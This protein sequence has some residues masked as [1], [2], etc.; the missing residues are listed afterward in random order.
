MSPLKVNYTKPNGVRTSTTINAQIAEAFFKTQC[1]MSGSARL[2]AAT[3]K[4]NWVSALTLYAQFYINK[5]TWQDKAT[6]E[7][8]LIDEVINFYKNPF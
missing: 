4:S 2:E 1:P 3:S 8:Y 5:Q 7:R 6:I